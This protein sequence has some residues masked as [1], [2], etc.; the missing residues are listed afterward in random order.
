MSVSAASIIAVLGMVAA[1][2]VS[3]NTIIEECERYYQNVNKILERVNEWSE[4]RFVT[5]LDDINDRLHKQYNDLIE[6]MRLMSD[7]IQA[8]HDEIYNSDLNS[9]NEIK[10]ANSELR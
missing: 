3:V 5:E 8:A 7:A 2:L 4:G 10:A 9:A 6:G 1:I